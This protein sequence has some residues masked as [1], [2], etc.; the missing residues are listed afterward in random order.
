[1]TCVQRRPNVFDV[2]ITLYKF[3][4]NVLFARLAGPLIYC[5]SVCLSVYMSVCLS[6]CLSLCL[7]VSPN[8][9]LSGY[10]CLH[11]CLISGARPIDAQ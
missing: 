7:S 6:V 1:M 3:Y 10:G 9:T 11:A 2:G 4:T 8:D 5:L